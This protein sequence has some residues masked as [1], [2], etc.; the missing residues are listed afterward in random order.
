M[1]I[2]ALI[3]ITIDNDDDVVLVNINELFDCTKVA[4]TRPS[5]ESRYCTNSATCQN[6]ENIYSSD[7]VERCQDPVRTDDTT[8]AVTPEQSMG[9]M[10]CTPKLNSVTSTVEVKVE[11]LSNVNNECTD[12][13]S[14]LV[15]YTQDYENYY[16][17]SVNQE[18]LS[19]SSARSQMGY[20]HSG[21]PGNFASSSG[22]V[23]EIKDETDVTWEHSYEDE[24]EVHQFDAQYGST[25]DY[26]NE[27]VQRGDTM[28]SDQSIQFYS[29]PQMSI[30][31]RRRKLNA[32]RLVTRKTPK[33]CVPSSVCEG[34]QVDEVSHVTVFTCSICGAVLTNRRSFVRHKQTHDGIVY[35]C[36]AC[37][38]ILSRSDKLVAHR[39]I[40]AA[41]LYQR[42][43]DNQY[44]NLANTY[45]A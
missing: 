44:E 8:L 14:Q 30:G 34:Q 35:Q 17:P 27:Y 1:K 19:M 4:N 31:S 42:S 23:I 29:S 32:A 39:R 33:K 41:S 2:E 37:G 21:F 15:D 38:K 10:Q 26:T 18:E 25:A 24:S 13:R 16:S 22:Q 5:T 9:L 40:C 3:G 6:G 45:N 11:P 36:D 28:P 12:S 43:Q 20:Q 7:Q